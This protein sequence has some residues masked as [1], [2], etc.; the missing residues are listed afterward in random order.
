MNFYA[1]SDF[2]E[3]VATVH[4][5]GQRHSIDDYEVQGQT[6]RLLTLGGRKVIT[7]CTFLDYHE[8]LAPAE[9]TTATPRTLYL[10]DVARRVV[11]MKDW[12]DDPSGFGMRPAP[13]VDFEGFARYEDYQ[14]FIAKR[15]KDRFKKNARLRERLAEDFGELSFSVDDTR[16]DVLDKSLTWKSQQLRDTGL[17]DVLAN[18]ANWEFYRELRRRGV[19]RASTLRARER[20]LAAWLGYVHEGYWSG[21]IFTYDHDPAL[22]K[23]S[24]GWQLMES[25]LKQCHAE[26]LR[27][28]DFSVG[29]SDYKLAYGT[30]VRLLSP[31]GT[32]P[33]GRRVTQQLKAGLKPVLARFPKLLEGAR[34]L[35]HRLRT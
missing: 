14:A 1:S 13:F 22:K 18:P 25:L 30:H 31:H 28:F 32:L 35:Q 33:L 20:L 15:T 5:P 3:T 34:T 23:Y 17:P 4:F 8:P 12:Q 29:S 7:Q 9:R 11:T 21:W 24:L 27:G 19:L 6:F 16:A 26:G 2:L 10:E